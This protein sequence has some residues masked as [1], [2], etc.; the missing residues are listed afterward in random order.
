MVNLRN[1]NLIQPPARLQGANVQL[2]LPPHAPPP[3]LPQAGKGAGAG[4][5]ARA[6]QQLAQPQ[7]VAQP[8]VN[9]YHNMLGR[10]GLSVAAITSLENLGLDYIQAFSEITEKDIPSIVKEVRR[11]NTLVCQTSQNYLH[12]LRY[13]VI[14]QERLQVN[15][16]PQ[17]FDEVTMRESLQRYQTS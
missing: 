13:W 4:R 12:V 16:T 3:P 11:N 9:E 7:Q 5:G 2:N 1:R 10:M 8:I 6:R 17:E 15:Y 14:R